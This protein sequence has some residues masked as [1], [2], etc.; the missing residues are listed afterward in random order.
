MT[1]ITVTM[2]DDGKLRG[3]TDKDQIAYGKFRK[4]IAELE[5]GELM[6]LETWFERSGPYHRRHMA[7]VGAFFDAQEQFADFDDFRK[8]TQVGAGHC[9]FVP[10]PAGRMV[11]LPKSIAYHKLDQ[12]DMEQLHKK[13]VDFLRSEHA[14]RFLWPHLSAEQT[15]MTIET[16]LVGFEREPG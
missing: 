5:P 2:G 1:T 4:R 8:W 11:A 6:W 16:I 9:D 7:M 14:Q 13:T 10:G 12:A 3:F 15:W